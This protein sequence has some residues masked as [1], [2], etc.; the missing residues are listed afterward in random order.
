MSAERNAAETLT[1]EK[2]RR[3]RKTS[4]RLGRGTFAEV[5]LGEW[6]NPDPPN[7]SPCYVAIK[8]FFLSKQTLDKALQTEIEIMRQLQHPNI[9]R[10]ISVIYIRG[11]DA[12][13]EEEEDDNDEDDLGSL[14]FNKVTP[15]EDRLWVILEFCAGGDFRT[16]LKDKKTGLSK[17]LSEKWACKYLLQIAEGLK[18]LRSQ[19]IIHRDLKPHNLLLSKSRKEIKIADFGFARIV[20]SEAL[21]ATMC[22]SP[23]YMAPEVLRGDEYNSKADLWSVGIIL[24]EMLCAERPFKNVQTIVA[25]Q[26]TVERA[27]IMFPRRVII[28]PECRDLLQR[29]L[30]KDP[31]Q[32]IEWEDFFEH[33]WLK[34]DWDNP[35]PQETIPS[36]I[37]MPRASEP[38]S[39]PSRD[40]VS[41]TRGIVRNYTTHL[42]SAPAPDVQSPPIRSP[43]FRSS[44]SFSTTPKGNGSVGS[45]VFVPASTPQGGS[46]PFGDRSGMGTQS[47]TPGANSIK[48]TLSDVFSTSFGLLKDSLKSGY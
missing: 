43:P 36:H 19:D 15:E 3:F 17:R 47:T 28:S 41:I 45:S 18:Y 16:F 38:I 33:P 5:F 4:K 20:G 26:N 13:G 14:E 10:L 2:G 9:V 22:G 44:I 29:L 32:R 8:Q 46:D 1:D 6:L 25:L 37:G 42:A 23:L 39:I 21:A 34:T 31:R 12:K 35:S 48:Q 30:I 40:S 24:Y 27:P 11:D 7:E